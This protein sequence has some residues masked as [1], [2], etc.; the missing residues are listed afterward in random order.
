[1]EQK[2]S[3][4]Y[5]ELRFKGKNSF[6]QNKKVTGENEIAFKPE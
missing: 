2:E 6:S 1:M 5:L 4:F 3:R